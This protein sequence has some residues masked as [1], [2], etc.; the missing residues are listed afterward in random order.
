MQIDRFA[1]TARLILAGIA[2]SLGVT[3]SLAQQPQTPHTLD[4]TVVKPETVGFSSD[5]LE[6]LHALMQQAVDQKQ[7]AGIVT[8][9]AR[10]GKVVDYRTYG[11]S[12][13]ASGKPIARDAIFR[14]FSMTKPVT[15]VAMMILYEQGKW[16]PSDPI[17]KFIPEFADL[18]VYK[19]TDA[20]GKVILTDP[21]H[22]PTMR[23]L[24]SHT[25]GFTY[26]FFGETPVD[27]M[28]RRCKPL[29]FKGPARVD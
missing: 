2:F 7:I 21:D 6:R 28:Y 22:A 17:S 29:C 25:A 18:K 1:F 5:R 8:I 20:N 19:G 9:L 16:L 4:L 12:D 26:G 24:M 14:D 13:V 15:G 27:K 11:Q 23:E 3:S 10:H